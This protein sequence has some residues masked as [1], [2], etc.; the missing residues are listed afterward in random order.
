MLTI[1]LNSLHE[2]TFTT[3]IIQLMSLVL[4]LFLE[5][6][7]FTIP[8]VIQLNALWPHLNICPIIYNIL[9]FRVSINVRSSSIVFKISSY[10]ILKVQLI[11]R[12][13]VQYHINRASNISFSFLSIDYV[14][15][16]CYV[17]SQTYV[18]IIILFSIYV[19]VFY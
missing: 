8:S 12:T 11:F 1:T 3:Y 16:S 4:G 9:F 15:H 17:T 10:V 14:T 2:V 18:F 5:R 13:I 6:V 19:Y 7:P